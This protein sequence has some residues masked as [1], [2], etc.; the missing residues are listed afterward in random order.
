MLCLLALEQSVEKADLR[1]LHEIL[2]CKR[3]S[4]FFLKFYDTKET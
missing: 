4:N 2:I 1:A 3:Q